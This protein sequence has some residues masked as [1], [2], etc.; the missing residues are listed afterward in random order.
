MLHHDGL[1]TEQDY[2]KCAAWVEVALANQYTDELGAGTLCRSKLDE[3][4]SSAADALATLW[5]SQYI[6]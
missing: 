5:K 1:G 2:I 3:Q 4:S 6:K